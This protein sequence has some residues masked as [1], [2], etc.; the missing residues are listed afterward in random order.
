M[1]LQVGSDLGVRA[2]Q[3]LVIGR[4][5]WSLGPLGPILKALG[6]GFALGAMTTAMVALIAG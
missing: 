6:I 5:K 1:E 2:S 4:T 3:V